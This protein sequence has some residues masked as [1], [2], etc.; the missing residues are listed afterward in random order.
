MNLGRF[1]R[2]LGLTQTNGKVYVAFN[3]KNE[4]KD[5]YRGGNSSDSIAELGG[6][7]QSVSSGISLAE[8]LRN[9]WT[10]GRFVAMHMRGQLGADL[11]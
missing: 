1:L 8:I 5:I 11:R 3:F 4:I 10:R 2:F 6:L 7:M 9:A